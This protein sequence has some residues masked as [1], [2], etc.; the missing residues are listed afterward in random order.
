MSSQS[1]SDD[2]R[3]NSHCEDLKFDLNRRIAEIHSAGS[4]ATFGAIDNFVHPGISIDSVGIVRL[5]LSPDDARALVQISRQAP[6]GK[7][8]ETLVDISVRKTWEIDAAKIQFLNKGW[9]C[10]LDRVVGEVTRGLGVD[11][12][13]QNVHAEL[14][15]MLL[16]EEG[17]MFKA[18]KEYVMP[19]SIEVRG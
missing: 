3:Y 7:G 8:T 5:P 14:Y 13:S 17:A 12:G 10:C 9:K 4:F 16:Y 11:G 19:R 1:D 2:D 15:K 6:F 18:H